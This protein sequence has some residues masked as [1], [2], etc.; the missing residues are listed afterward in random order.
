MT[1]Q[2]ALPLS[3]GWNKTPESHNKPLS[4]RKTMNEAAVKFARVFGA[5]VTLV[6]LCSGCA[7]GPQPMAYEDLNYFQVDCKIAVQQRTM[8]M[9]M[10]RTRDEAAL[11]RFIGNGNINQQI[12]YNLHLLRYCP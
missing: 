6:S 12:N 1:V 8:L 11:D 2:T 9:S 4:Q 7:S 5:C 3:T 10:K